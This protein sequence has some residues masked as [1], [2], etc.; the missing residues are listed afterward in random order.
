M[1]K[2]IPALPLRR[3]GWRMGIVLIVSLLAPAPAVAQADDSARR[4]EHSRPAVTVGGGDQER[5]FRVV[6]EAARE[7]NVRAQNAM[8][9]AYRFGAGVPADKAAR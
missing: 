7:G 6:E 1:R 3:V 5:H 9:N 2:R 4:L 8:C